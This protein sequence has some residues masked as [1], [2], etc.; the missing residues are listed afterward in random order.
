MTRGIPD[1]ADLVFRLGTHRLDA[2]CGVCGVTTREGVAIDFPT[3]ALGAAAISRLDG[4]QPDPDD[5]KVLRPV[6]MTIEFACH[7][8]CLDAFWDVI[9]ERLPNDV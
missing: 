8:R 7:A 6:P 2:P 5:A 3:R 1:A 4:N 9:G